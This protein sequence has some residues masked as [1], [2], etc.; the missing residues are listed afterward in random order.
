[1][2]CQLVVF[3]FGKLGQPGDF[4]K[5]SEHQAI[6]P[7][8]IV[9]PRLPLTPPAGNGLSLLAN[10][11]IYDPELLTA[12]DLTEVLTFEMNLKHDAD[13]FITMGATAE[14]S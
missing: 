3:T 4:G 11:T 14:A 6:G 10:L 7:L 2:H 12:H 5:S 1:M 8:H 13:S 9:R